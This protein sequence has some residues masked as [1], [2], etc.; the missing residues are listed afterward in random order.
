MTT[1]AVITPDNLNTEFD[2][3]I[4]TP[5]KISLKIDGTSIVKS[6]GGVLSA[7]GTISTT[8]TATIT[9]TGTGAVLSPLAAAINL[10]LTAGNQLTTDGTGIYFKETTFSATSSDGSV[11]IV[12]GGTDGHTPNFSVNTT[13]VLPNLLTDAF[14]VTLGHI[15]T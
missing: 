14:G 7:H 10:S 5:N 13:N 3:G 8:N 12:A 4:I 9:L 6:G 15:G 2:V 1:Q 11:T